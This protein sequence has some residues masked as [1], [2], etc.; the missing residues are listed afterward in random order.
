MALS[1]QVTIKVRL[2]SRAGQDKLVGWDSDLHDHLVVRVKAPPVDGRAN[3][4][5]IGILADSLGLAKSQIELL[6]GKRSRNKLLGLGMGDEA[7]RQWA[8]TVPI[9]DKE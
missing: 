5:L 4:A 9:V 2:T 6:R 1:S 8:M 7:Y 3:I